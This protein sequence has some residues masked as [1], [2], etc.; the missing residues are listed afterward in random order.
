MELKLLCLKLLVTGTIT[1][2][3]PRVGRYIRTT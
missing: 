3:L 1:E 2:G